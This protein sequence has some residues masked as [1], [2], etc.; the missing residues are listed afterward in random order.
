LKE[1]RRILDEII[2]EAEGRAS[3]DTS[4]PVE[5]EG[6]ATESN[7]NLG[8]VDDMT[9]AQIKEAIKAFLK[10]EEFQKDLE[11][12]IKKALTGDEVK[13]SF[14]SVESALA[15]EEVVKS[16]AESLS[17]TEV[18]KNSVQDLTKGL[19]NTI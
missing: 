18:F 9:E 15:S 5:E 4:T 16:F 10:S 19:E 14:L 17:N 7:F 8:G 6:S 12:A 11:G 1:A 13:K 3:T 2:A